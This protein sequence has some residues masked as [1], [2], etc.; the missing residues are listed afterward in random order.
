[1]PETTPVTPRRILDAALAGVSS[2]SRALPKKADTISTYNAMKNSV[3]TIMSI[4]SSGTQQIVI[5][6]IFTCW[7]QESDLYTQMS[8]LRSLFLH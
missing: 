1:V 5:S 8:R 7:C 4:R 2:S 6:K 3:S